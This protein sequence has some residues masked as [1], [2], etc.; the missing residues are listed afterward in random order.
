MQAKEK[1]NIT[2]K[3]GFKKLEEFNNTDKW[4]PDDVTIQEL[5]EAQ[6]RERA[7]DIAIICDHGKA[8][9]SGHYLTYEQ[10]NEKANQLANCLR[11]KGA[12][13]DQIIGIIVDR[14]FA[15]II[16]I[17]GIL[18]AG[19]AYLPISQENPKERIHYMLSD[20]EVKIL[21]V[22]DK[23]FEKISFDGHVINLEDSKVYTGSAE[24]LPVI[25]TSS[26][27][28]YVIYTSGSTGK[29]KGVMIEHRSLMNRLN[30][31]QNAYSINEN[32]VILQKTPYYF[33]VSV[34]ELF[35]W[36][37][38]GAKLCLL[39]PGGEG[40][41]LA[42]VETIKK[43]QISVMHFVPSMLNVFLDYLE[44]K[45]AEEIKKLSCVKQVFASGEALTPSHV[46]KYNNVFGKYTNAKLTNL[47][48]PTEATVDVSYFDCPTNGN[49]EKIPIGKPIDNIKFFIIK[50]NKLLP[51]GETGELCI[52]GVGVA[53][54]YINNTKL[55]DE[56]FVENPFLPG[57]VMYRTG[58]IAR[59]L[60]DGNIDYLGREDTQ[61]K[62]RGLRIELGEI[63]STIRD[64]HPIN[65]CITIVKKYSENIILIIAYV[66]CKE[67][68]DVNKLKNYL[69]DFLPEYMVPNNFI[70]ID[71]VPVLPNGKADR[72]ALPEAIIT[73]K[74]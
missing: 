10:L 23:T 72:N 4:F 73:L 24:N 63:E 66:V 25:N 45:S 34:W 55:S 60:P 13:P 38:Q 67:E 16:G 40:I 9:G 5:F 64:F 12:V 44:G 74:N 54:G 42:I 36:G 22:Q 35:W 37:M 61:V 59:W 2:L 51:V 21:L 7:S 41:P 68:L 18:K 57:E 11:S 49:I 65:D 29:P 6:A 19:C 69:K 1:D 52:S 47:Y 8:F 27:L 53:R 48:G 50:D 56:K 28:A 46:R 14:S 32:D 62:I 43:H 70:Q 30:W 17:L 26:D 15:M 31:M 33:D 3:S 20:S 58:D 39:M 71:Q